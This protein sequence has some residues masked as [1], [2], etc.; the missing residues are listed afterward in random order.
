MGL[1]LDEIVH[2]EREI[3]QLGSE[4][5][6]P[7]L[8]P[9]GPTEASSGHPGSLDTAESGASLGDLGPD[10]LPWFLDARFLASLTILRRRYTRLLQACRACQSRWQQAVR[11]AESLTTETDCLTSDTARLTAHL[12]FSYLAVTRNSSDRTVAVATETTARQH[13]LLLSCEG[14][15][16]SLSRL[17]LRFHAEAGRLRQRL[18]DL[19]RLTEVTACDTA[20]DGRSRSGAQLHRLHHCLSVAETLAGRL[21][22]RLAARLEAT[23]L[24]STERTRIEARLVEVDS[25]CAEHLLTGRL[26][27]ANS[28]SE[29]LARLAQWRAVNCDLEQSLQRLMDEFE[30]HTHRLIEDPVVLV[31]LD[32]LATKTGHLASSGEHSLGDA[33]LPWDDNEAKAVAEHLAAMEA[34]TSRHTSELGTQDVCSQSSDRDTHHHEA[35]PNKV[36]L[37]F[38][39]LE[40]VEAFKCR[41]DVLRT[42][43]TVGVI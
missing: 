10:D 17:S 40:V 5:L 26:K 36:M 7:L 35:D 15:R 6:L 9:S 20:P 19:D 33:Q 4:M 21:D 16:D 42:T 43:T 22:A 11:Q 30:A 12:L 25:Q 27:E 13:I 2:H 1:L 34:E 18:S 32:H 39:G 41:L 38:D 37:W 3:E 31:E 14:L 8:Q 23:Q 29:L 28:P 24:L